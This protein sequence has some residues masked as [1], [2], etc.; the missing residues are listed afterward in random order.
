MKIDCRAAALLGLVFCQAPAPMAARAQDAGIIGRAGSVTLS[1]TEAHDLFAALPAPTR[2]GLGKDQAEAL[3]RGR[4]LDKLV[5]DDLANAGFDRRPDVERRLAQA[6]DTLLIELYLDA[7][8]TVKPDYPTE[9]EAR[10]YYDANKAAF[11]PPKRYKLAQIFIADASDARSNPRIEQA[12]ARLRVKNANFALIAHELSDNKA[13]AAKGGE[14]GW[15]GEP[16]LAPEIRAALA[17]VKKGELSAPIR[18]KDGFHIVHVLEVAEAGKEPLDFE[19]VKDTLG[20]EM[21]R[22]KIVADKQAFIESLV[23]AH[24]VSIDETALAEAFKPAK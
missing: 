22:R 3:L 1:S 23:K 9:A 13:E 10:A 12:Q 21:R 18:M 16:A 17:K 19:L 24:P 7:H 20:G 14:I 2:E 4:L 11:I 5:M 15:L 8:V 6:H